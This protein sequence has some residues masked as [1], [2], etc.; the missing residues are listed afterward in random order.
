MQEAK[1]VL[2]I[3]LSY[4]QTGFYHVNGVQG[5]LIAAVLAYMMPSWRRLP[6]TAVV[7]VIANVALTVMIPV[8]S[9]GAAFKLP[10]VV[11][12]EYWKYLAS[13][14][15]GYLIVVSIFFLVKSLMLG[16]SG[17]HAHGHH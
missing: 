13:L 10:P 7:A 11:E 3:I 9:N 16:G 2:Q 14:F 15:A 4:F 5:L 12:I 1:D 8:L 6:V 17:G